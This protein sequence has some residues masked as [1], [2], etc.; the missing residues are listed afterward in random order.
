MSPR[1]ARGHALQKRVRAKVLLLQYTA[2]VPFPFFLV[3]DGNRARVSIPRRTG[4]A[5]SGVVPGLEP[6]CCAVSCFCDFPVRSAEGR[7]SAVS[8]G[9]A[10]SEKQRSGRPGR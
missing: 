9:G 2:L 4:P 8:G 5:R 10:A 1:R 7:A 3:T 6:A